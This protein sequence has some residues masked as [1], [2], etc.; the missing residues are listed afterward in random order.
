MSSLWEI[1]PWT[2]FSRSYAYMTTLWSCSQVIAFTFN[3]IFHLHGHVMA[4][5]TFVIMYLSFDLDLW[6]WLKALSS[7]Q[8]QIK[9][10]LTASCLWTTHLLCQPCALFLDQIF[11]NVFLFIEWYNKYSWPWIFFSRSNYE[12]PVYWSKHPVQNII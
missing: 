12:V 8:G 1:W 10:R 7:I 5:Y 3:I 2:F 4:V 11:L 9:S 6:P